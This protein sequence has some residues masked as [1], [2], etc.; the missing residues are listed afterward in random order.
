MQK[1]YKKILGIIFPN[2]CLACNKIIDC[3][4]LFCNDDWQKLQFIT[5]P[6]CRICSQPF[7]SEFEAHSASSGSHSIL[8]I[9]CLTIQPS[10]DSSITI[11]RYNDLLKKIVGDLKYHDGTNLSKKF[12]KILSQK[13]APEVQNYNLIIAVPLHK[14]R[15][16]ERKFNQAILLAKAILQNLSND[17]KNNLKFY[18]DILLR[19][20]YT[21]AQVKLDQKTRAKN[22]H[23]AFSVNKKYLDQIKDS[24]ILL[25]DDVITTGATLENCASILKKAGAKK[26]TVVTIAHTILDKN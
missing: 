22:L 20:R 5:E 8:C 3:E 12:G 7:I 23:G 10:Y 26:V 4:G 1:L 6:K 17:A 18:P 13:I 9:K 19:T 16:R 2:K 25:I 14:Q 11:F 15:L 24:S 21:K